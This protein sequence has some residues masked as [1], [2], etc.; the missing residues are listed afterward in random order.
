MK[1]S[2]FFIAGLLG[3][4]ISDGQSRISDNSFLIEEAY[5]QERGVVQHIFTS[6]LDRHFKQGEYSFTQEWPLGSEVHQVSYS[7][8][9]SL[10]PSF[11]LHDVEIVY[12][13]Q[14]VSQNKLFI[15]PAFSL[16]L[17][18]NNTHASEDEMTGF[19]INI[20]LSL[21]ISSRF[22]FHANL[23][24]TSSW[25]TSKKS[26]IRPEQSEAFQYGAS[27]IYF[28]SDNFNFMLEALHTS[29]FDEFQS[30]ETEVEK[31]TLINPGFRFAINFSSGLQ[32]VPGFSV[33]FDIQ[34]E[35]HFYFL[36]LSFEHPF[37]KTTR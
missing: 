3:T 22:S 18:L 32:V 7:L 12:R 16:I 24:N 10:D 1:K 28:L 2:I 29:A 23:G 36:Y 8:P 5:N 30:G 17:P 21:E 35:K 33:P 13:Y 11:E 19:Q 14:L 9:F 4:M 25:S 37:K 26:E 31:S 34:S 6:Q 15:A 27:L 20:P